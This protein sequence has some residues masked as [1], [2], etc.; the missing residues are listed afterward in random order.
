VSSFRKDPV[1]VPEPA[2]PT[3][4]RSVVLPLPAE[5]AWEVVTE[6]EH[7]E[8]WLA[9][10]VELDLRPGGEGRFRLDDGSERDAVVESVDDGRRY[11]FWWRSTDEDAGPPTRVEIS[12]DPEGDEATVLTVVE[13]G[14]ADA[15]LQAVAAWAWE[16]TLSACAGASASMLAA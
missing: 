15:G 8:G 14:H 11:A 2:T 13:S 10:E 4:E 9:R 12:L 6:R 3:V 5:E 7:L 16:T 1:P